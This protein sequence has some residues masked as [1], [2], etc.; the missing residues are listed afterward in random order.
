MVLIVRMSVRIS[1]D[2]LLISLQRVKKY[3][4]C[5]N[6]KVY[7][8]KDSFETMLF[9]TVA[10]GMLLL[11]ILPFGFV[12]FAVLSLGIFTPKDF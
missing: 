10:F 6:S 3:F 11:D 4:K 12:S 8:L 7:L 1:L 2:V 5:V 9:K